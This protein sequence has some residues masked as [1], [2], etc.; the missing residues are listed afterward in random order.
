MPDFMDLAAQEI[1][2]FR[3]IKYTSDDLDLLPI[4]SALKPNRTVFIGSDVKCLEAHRRGFDSFIMTTLNM[5]P[6][7]S[8]KI[9]EQFKSTEAEKAQ[10]ELTAFVQRVLQAGGGNWVVS[11]KQEFS[12]QPQLPFKVGIARKPL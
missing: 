10:E 6:E 2:N 5:C 9:H 1:P 11:M 12:C 7:L 3:G 8:G 4:E